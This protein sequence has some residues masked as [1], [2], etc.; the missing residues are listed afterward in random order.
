MKTLTHK[1]SERIHAQGR[2]QERFGIQWSKRIRKAVMEQ[3]HSGKAELIDKRENE[4]TEKFLGPLHKRQ[5]RYIV[6]IDGKEIVAA[7]DPKQNEIATLL[8][9]EWCGD[10]WAVERR[11]LLNQAAQRENE[12]DRAWLK[13]QAGIIAEDAKQA[14]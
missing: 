1:Q 13:R 7:Y 11:L 3:I 9:L 2:A 6:V 8:P 4:A 5:L 14:T 10:K 12:W